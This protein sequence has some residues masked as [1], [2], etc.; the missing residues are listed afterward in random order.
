MHPAGA[1]LGLLSL[2]ASLQPCLR[3]GLWCWRRAVPHL[4]SLAASM[5]AQCP[6]WLSSELWAG[7]EHG[8]VGAWMSCEAQHE[9][10]HSKEHCEQR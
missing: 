10:S 3:R 4:L 1:E 2:S 8:A 9:Q 6:A 7:F 5:S